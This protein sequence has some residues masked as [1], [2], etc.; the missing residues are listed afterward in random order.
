MAWC[1]FSLSKSSS[2]LIDEL[3]VAESKFYVQIV[4]I[5]SFAGCFHVVGEGEGK[6]PY[7]SFSGKHVCPEYS[8]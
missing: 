5:H 6:L 8:W 3:L 1:L 2:R 7:I 4:G